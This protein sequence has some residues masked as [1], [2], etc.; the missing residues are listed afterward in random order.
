MNGAMF[1]ACALLL[2]ICA[3]L[4]PRMAWGAHMAGHD[5]LLTAS[6]AHTHHDGHSHE[7]AS[8]HE[9]AGAA[10]AD[11]DTGDGFTHD[12]QAAQALVTAVVLPDA[13]DAPG[14]RPQDGAARYAR[15]PSHA[16]PT[17]ADSLLRPPRLA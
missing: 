11:P 14:F 10:L 4:M 17:H 7:T 12:H 6:A 16:P 15:L 3:L 2:M 8:D 13:V 1:R 5:D 9:L